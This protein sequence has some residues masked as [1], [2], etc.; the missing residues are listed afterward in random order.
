MLAITKNLSLNRV[1]GV[2]RPEKVEQRSRFGTCSQSLRWSR[3]AGIIGSIAVLTI[4]WISPAPAA[5]P[6]VNVNEAARHGL[7]RVWFAQIDVDQA[8]NRVAHWTLHKDY[9]FALTTAGTIHALDA[10]TGATR[11]VA[12]VGSPERL[13]VGPAANDVYLAV[14]NGSRLHVLDLRD[15]HLIW[16]RTVG[17]APAAAP[18]LSG[19]YVY[20]ALLNGRIE[21]H[22]LDNPATPVWFYQSE[23][24]I[25][26]APTVADQLLSWTT[27]RGNLYAAHAETP[28]MIFRMETNEEFVA[29]VAEFDTY[30]YA[31]SLSGYLYC[32]EGLSGN[33]RWR[34][35]TGF[36]I[37]STPAIVGEKAF[38]VSEAPALHAVDTKTGHSLWTTPDASQF[39]AQGPKQVYGMDRFGSLLIL[40]RKTGRIVGRLTTGEDIGAIVNDQTDRIYLVNDRGLVQCLRELDAA[41]PI[42]YRKPLGKKKASDKKAKKGG[43]EK[44]ASAKD[45]AGAEKKPSNASPAPATTGQDNNSPESNE[46]PSAADPFSDANP[47]GE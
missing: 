47:F 40:D 1:G 15:G 46:A 39:V 19:R 21:G 12:R 14:L 44:K 29:S 23:G 26:Q 25:F 7:Q 43:K 36:P 34:Y 4:G 33:E 13:T 9:L 5:S 3:F 11:W 31:A 41:E 2:Q 35:A 45:S 20:V 42:L 6:L 32:V 22:R 17:S 24:R 8:R 18:V 27:D 16:S 30:L 10:E 38:V 28:G 37:A